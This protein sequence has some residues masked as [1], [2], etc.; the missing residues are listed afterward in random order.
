MKTLWSTA[1]CLSIIAMPCLADESATNTPKQANAARGLEDG[2]IDEFKRG[3]DIY[4]QKNKPLPAK[5]ASE[6]TKQEKRDF[7]SYALEKGLRLPPEAYGAHVDWYCWAISNNNPEAIRALVKAGFNVG[8]YKGRFIRI[9]TCTNKTGL[10]ASF[11]EENIALFKAFFEGGISPDVTLWKKPVLLSAIEENKIEHVRYLLSRGANARQAYEGKTLIEYATAREMTALLE[12]YGGSKKPA[13]L[14]AI[15]HNDRDAAWQLLSSGT[16]ADQVY[17]GKSFIEY[18]T[19]TQMA[20]L[21]EEYGGFEKIAD[22]AH[23][24]RIFP[25]YLQDRPRR[26]QNIAIGVAK[27]NPQLGKYLLGLSYES[28]AKNGLE[29]EALGNRSLALIAFREAGELGNADA[30]I[31]VA[32]A[33]EDGSIVK[34]NEAIATE[35]YFLALARNS[36]VAQA[37]LIERGKLSAPRPTQGLTASAASER[38]PATTAETEGSTGQ[39]VGNIFGFIAGAYLYSQGLQAQQAH[40]NA[41]TRRAVQS[42]LNTWSEEQRRKTLLQQSSP[43][44]LT[45]RPNVL[46]TQLNCQ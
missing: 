46:G 22:R 30:L 11:E 33:F 13:L 2:N 18:A 44:R 41:Q 20:Y 6:I 31:K 38:A 9:G 7:L 3:V 40:A 35:F 27:T 12:R 39:T 5:W 28:E 34:A 4:V 1:L 21:L 23:L 19:S 37:R 24:D 45:C 43:V 15:Q 10:G 25:R 8:A 17:E 14:V 42:E 32:E 26:A 29:H 16:P 36:G